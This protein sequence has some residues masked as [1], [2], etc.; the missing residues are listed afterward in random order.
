M[1]RPP[2]NTADEIL[3]NILEKAIRGRQQAFGISPVSK[4]QRDEELDDLEQ[5]SSKFFLVTWD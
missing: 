2:L 3:E 4:I 5:I 1:W